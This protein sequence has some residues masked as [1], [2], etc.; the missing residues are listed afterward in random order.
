[1]DIVNLNELRVGKENIDG[2]FDTSWFDS[3][4]IFDDVLLVT[5]ISTSCFVVKTSE[6]L[7]L[8][9]SILGEQIVFDAICDAIRATGWDPADIRHFFI[10]HGHFDHTGCGKWIKEAFSPR[11][12]MSRIDYEFWG[13]HPVA[14]RLRDFEPTDLLEGDNVFQIGD[15]TFRQFFTPGHTPGCTSLIF[16]VHDRGHR[17]MA[18]LFGGSGA[19]NDMLEVV[20]QMRSIDRFEELMAMHHVDAQ[21]NQHPF[22]ENGLLRLEYAKQRLA[23]MPNC[24]VLGEQGCQRYISQYREACYLK[25]ERLTQGVQVAPGL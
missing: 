23:H 6:G 20:K 17:H 7:V 14:G 25:I 13:E 4:R 11:I 9:D 3:C 5:N 12:Y 18:G 19:P 16:E 24:Y 2:M 8:I 15:H 1:M 22:T 10:T 21:L